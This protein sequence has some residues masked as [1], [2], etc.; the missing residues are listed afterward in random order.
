[1]TKAIKKAKDL[2]IGNLIKDG[3]DLEQLAIEHL[4]CLDNG[5]C[6]FDP[7]PLTEEWLLRFG[8][9]SNPYQDR[10]ELDKIHIQCDK[11]KGTTDLWIEGAPHI[12]YVHSLQNYVF[13]LTGQELELK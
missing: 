2:R 5:R 11:T 10:Y 7:I 8:F 6:E 13:A 4:I 1:M 9:V 12:K 3:K